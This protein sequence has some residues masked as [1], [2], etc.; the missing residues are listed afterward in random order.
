[1]RHVVAPMVTATRT[2]PNS[3]QE[4]PYTIASISSARSS[5]RVTK[6]QAASPLQTQTSA[7]NVG[8]DI[9]QMCHQQPT[10]RGRCCAATA[11]PLPLRST[12][13]WMT[14]GGPLPG[15]PCGPGPGVERDRAVAPPGLAGSCT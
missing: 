10:P 7:T 3:R 8:E 6:C 12:A 4:W 2:D 15:R 11:R 14:T 1:M 9:D 13:S 5:G